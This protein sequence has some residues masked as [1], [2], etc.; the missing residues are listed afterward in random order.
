MSAIVADLAKW[1]TKLPIWQ[2]H[3]L[4]LLGEKGSLDEADD[5]VLYA[6]LRASARDEAGAIAR[7][8]VPQR[9]APTATLG[10]AHGEA[11]NDAPPTVRLVAIEEVRGVN[12]LSSDR[13]LTFGADGLT[14]IY[15]PNGSGKSGYARLLKRACRAR[16]RRERVLPNARLSPNEVE[17]PGASFRLTVDNELVNHRWTETA[18]SAALQ[19]I[20]VFDAH[21]SAGYLDHQGDFSYAP[22]GLDL[23]DGLS[24]ACGRLAA[25]LQRDAEAAEPNL[26]PLERLAKSPTEAGAAVAALSAE[27]SLRELSAVAKLSSYDEDRLATLER[28]LKSGDPAARGQLLR[29]WETR[30]RALAA[31]CAELAE[32][33]SEAAAENLRSL[34]ETTRAARRAA[35]A[36]ARDLGTDLGQDRGAS[37]GVLPGTGGEPWAQLIQAARTFVAVSHPGHELA[38]LSPDARCPLCQEP[39][40]AANERLAAFDAFLHQSAEITWRKARQAAVAPYEALRSLDVSTTIDPELEA[41]L[42]ADDAPTASYA[43]TRAFLSSIGPRRDAILAACATAELHAWTV[44]TPPLPPC[45]PA[46]LAMADRLQREI[47]VLASASSAEQRRQTEAELAEYTARQSLAALWPIVT[48]V[49]EKLALKAELARCAKLVR[50]NAITSKSS[51]LVGALVLSG[52]E[53]KLSE[54]LRRLSVAGLAVTVRLVAKKGSTLFQLALAVPGETSARLVLSEGEQRM[55]TLAAM[56]AELRLSRSTSAVV[57]DDPVTALDHERRALV[58]RRLVD[59]AATR[60]VIVWTH[61]LPFAHELR[62]LAGSSIAC[63]TLTL[64]RGPKGFGVPSPSLPPDEARGAI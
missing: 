26:L 13:L 48:E 3:A 18:P 59:E 52:V 53:E 11:T 33:T 28:S 54:E 58:A 39:L 14:V 27:T 29:S 9:L 17:P 50:T 34:V 37:N 44:L 30:L 31:R 21:C 16:D 12:A 64:G 63:D 60:Q 25:R 56:F 61:D 36:A 57:F 20:T 55:V 38:T 43:A 51:E 41:L 2:Q 7:P 23:L 35:D 45:H 10:R 62:R 32:K 15:G 8:V 42:E 5:D 1:S 19:A 46:L 49:V 6:M 4:F 24:R 22:F 40:G 47:A